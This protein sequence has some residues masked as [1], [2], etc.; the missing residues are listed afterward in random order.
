MPVEELIGKTVSGADVLETE[1]D[2]RYLLQPIVSLRDG[3]IAGYEMVYCRQ[4]KPARC[5]QPDSGTGMFAL[6]A[7]FRYQNHA[8]DQKL[9]LPVNPDIL[10]DYRFLQGRTAGNIVFETGPFHFFQAGTQQFAVSFGNNDCGYQF[11]FFCASHPQYIKLPPA[12]IRMFDSDSF[13]RAFVKGVAEFCRIAGVSSIA[14]GVENRKQ[15]IDLIDLGIT[16][17]QG[18][19]LQKPSE[20]TDVLEKEA[21]QL[22]IETN[23]RKNHINSNLP[24]EVYIANL[25]TETATLPPDMKVETVYERIRKDPDCFG[26]CIVQNGSVQGII[27]RNKLI[28]NMSGRYGFTLYERKPVSIL[29]DRSFFSADY[30]MPVS[31]VSELAMERNMDRLYDFIVVTRNGKYLGTVTVRDLLLKSNEIQVASARCQNPLTG[32]PGN[33]IINQMLSRCV[34]SGL[35]YCVLYVDIDNFKAYNDVYGFEKG[36]SII[37]SL[38]QIMTVSLPPDQ[39]AGHVGGDDF[40]AVF[41]AGNPEQYCADVIREFNADRSAYYT[42]EDFKKGYITAENR[43]GVIENFPLISLSIAGIRDAGRH[44][45]NSILLSEELARLKK[46][47][48]MHKGNSFYIKNYPQP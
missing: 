32:L 10:A 35:S 17:A 9:F 36:D 37:Q 38:A 13:A 28:L 2:D 29:M 33:I 46:D 39:F 34:S 22:I 41:T 21:Y 16:Y 5:G 8:G 27:T 18:D 30:R 1:Y 6:E 7:F 4:C 19:Y 15:L 40:V 20:Q 11:N 26:Y 31:T 47:V 44:F 25:C 24:T 43:H 14:E 45:S 3:G 23:R 12:V 48:K 42:H